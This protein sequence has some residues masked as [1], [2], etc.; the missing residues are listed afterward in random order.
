[1]AAPKEET[2]LSTLEG[3]TAP[4]DEVEDEHFRP[5]GTIFLLGCFVVAL[6]LLWLSVYI[7]LLSRGVTV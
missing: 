1:M 2:T 5:I 3:D 4:D 6:V 7:I